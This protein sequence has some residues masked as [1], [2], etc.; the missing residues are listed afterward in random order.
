MATRYEKLAAN[1]LAM[2]TLAAIMMWRKAKGRRS[3]E[4]GAYVEPLTP[5]AV[6]AQGGEAQGS[7]PFRVALR[8]LRLVLGR[9]RFCKLDC[10]PLGPASPGEPPGHR[11]P[12]AS[13][14]RQ[15][16][17]RCP[18]PTQLEDTLYDAPMIVRWPARLA[19]APRR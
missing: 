1:Y 15:V 3:A 2:V 4:R 5:G 12:E 18:G 16:A 19:R 17:P 7:V 13:A 9:D 14:L 10:R 11:P 8:I 6:T